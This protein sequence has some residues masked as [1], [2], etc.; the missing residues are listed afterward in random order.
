MENKFRIKKVNCPQ[1]AIANWRSTKSYT[2]I[3]PGALRHQ[4]RSFAYGQRKWKPVYW[5]ECTLLAWT[6]RNFKPCSVSSEPT[7][8]I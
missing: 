6:Y 1:N 8:F 5:H 2:A 4:L 7:L 3:D